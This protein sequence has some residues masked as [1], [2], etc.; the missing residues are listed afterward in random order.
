MAIEEL[1]DIME[2]IA[3]LLNIY[4]AEKRCPFISAMKRRI[5]DA[6]AIEN[7]LYE[8]PSRDQFEAERPE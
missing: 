4:G 5:R 1:D 3:N 7:K 8:R 2:E 6:V